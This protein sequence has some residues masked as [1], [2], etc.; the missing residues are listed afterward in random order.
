MPSPAC[1][2]ATARLSTRRC[3]RK[4]DSNPA[5][6]PAMT[7][8]LFGMEIEYGFAVCN[9]AGKRARATEWAER[10]YRLATRCLP[11]LPA[12]GCGGMFLENGARF[13]MDCG[14]PEMTTPECAN[15]WDVVRYML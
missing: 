7:E 12:A 1:C 13:Y 14:H 11:N 5:K 3:D 6:R 15:P 4:A 8:R 9:A 2:P 10:F